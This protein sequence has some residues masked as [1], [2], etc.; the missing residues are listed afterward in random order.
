MTQMIESKHL[1]MNDSLKK[2]VRVGNKQD[3]S[4]I[5]TSRH[6]KLQK[7]LH[8]VTTNICFSLSA[9]ILLLNSTVYIINYVRLS[10]FYSLLL[11]FHL[12][13]TFSFFFSPFHK[14]RNVENKLPPPLRTATLY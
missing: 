11:S 7:Q 5:Q 8:Y 1:L 3:E 14:F 6:S 13:L 9:V 2:I 12:Y 4:Y 10:V